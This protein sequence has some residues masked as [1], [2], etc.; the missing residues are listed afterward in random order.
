M[1]GIKLAQF[2]ILSLDF[3]KKSK[4]MEVFFSNSGTP[5]FRVYGAGK[6][7]ISDNIAL[8][9]LPPSLKIELGL[10]LYWSDCS[11]LKLSQLNWRDCC[12]A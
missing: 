7:R 6:C 9:M 3:G 11:R 10:I 12:D 2:R 1:T 8:Q 4:K 5:T